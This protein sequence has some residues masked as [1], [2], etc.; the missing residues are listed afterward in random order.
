[1]IK[2]YKCPKCGRGVA[3]SVKQ[4]VPSR[5]RCRC[6]YVDYTSIFSSLRYRVAEFNA[7]CID[8]L[9]A[10]ISSY[11]ER[12]NFADLEK[13]I[14]AWSDVYKLP[15]NIIVRLLNVQ[16]Q[17]YYGKSNVIDHDV[18]ELKKKIVCISMIESNG[19]KISDL[20]NELNN[21]THSKATTYTIEPLKESVEMQYLR[22]QIER[23]VEEEKRLKTALRKALECNEELKKRLINYEPNV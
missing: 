11:V 6:G 20:L 19:V 18:E 5:L 2:I 16:L 10:D 3:V 1:M 12:G 13:E 23:K 8:N 15:H 17:N 14:Y 21:Y 7:N 4:D 9:L 22:Y